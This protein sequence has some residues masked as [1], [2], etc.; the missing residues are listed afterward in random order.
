MHPKKHCLIDYNI[1]YE[2]RRYRSPQ[3]NYSLFN[4]YDNGIHLSLF[5]LTLEWTLQW[6]PWAAKSQ[7]KEE[8]KILP[9][10]LV[11]LPK[12]LV[13]FWPSKWRRL[14]T[15]Q[16]KTMENLPTPL[17]HVRCPNVLAAPP[18]SAVMPA[19]PL[20]A[21]CFSNWKKTSQGRYQG[22]LTHSLHSS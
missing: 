2:R 17:Q 21:A 18:F 22:T 20:Q 4:Y 7:D 11:P 15:T 10:C 19:N 12:P 9:P 5:L 14:G 13:S 1:M 6:K 8:R 16:R 3:K